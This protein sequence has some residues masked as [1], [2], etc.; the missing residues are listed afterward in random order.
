[1]VPDF[2]FIFFMQ[3]QYSQIKDW[4]GQKNSNITNVLFDNCFDKWKKLVL[5]IER[6][7]IRLLCILP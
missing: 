6:T 5:S 2:H 1:M 4:H 7:A 3:I